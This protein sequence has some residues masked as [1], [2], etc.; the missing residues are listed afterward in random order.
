MTIQ[1]SNEASWHSESFSALLDFPSRPVHLHAA[2]ETQLFEC[3]T[4]LVRHL[5]PAL[6][7]DYTKRQGWL[8]LASR[9]EVLGMGPYLPSLTRV[10]GSRQLSGR[11]VLH[12]DVLAKKHIKLPSYDLQAVSRRVLGWETPHFSDCCMSPWLRVPFRYRHACV[13]YRLRLCFIQREIARVTGVIAQ[14]T[15]MGRVFGIDPE[16]ILTRGTQWRVEAML[17]RAAHRQGYLLLSP[18]KQQV[19]NQP[20]MAATPMVLE[21]ASRIYFE[22]VAVLDYQS[23]YPSIIVAYNY[24]FSTCLGKTHVRCNFA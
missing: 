3:L 21:P 16:S 14:H 10:Y 20:A 11:L 1:V 8:W 5:D 7:V 2:C 17:L 23:L 24:C 12:V 4:Q 9:A 19:T 13:A 15:Q 22:P 18:T 6:L